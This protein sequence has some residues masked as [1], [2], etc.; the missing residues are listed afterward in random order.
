MSGILHGEVVCESEWQLMD[1]EG[2]GPTTTYLPHSGLPHWT[3]EVSLSINLT[4]SGLLH[5][6]YNT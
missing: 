5:G 3:V 1:G 4:L 2:G 6:P